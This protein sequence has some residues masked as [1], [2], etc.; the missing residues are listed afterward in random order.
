MSQHTWL[1][2][3]R[4]AV[5]GASEKKRSYGYK[6]TRKLLN[7]NYTT[8]PISKEYETILDEK[9]Y[10]RLTDYEGKID[11]VNFVVNPSIGIEVLDDVIEKGIKKIML[12]PGTYS[13]EIVKK[14][15]EN[16]IEVLES[17]IL[18]LLAWSNK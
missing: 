12:Q 10:S 13:E 17:C 1:K 8:I 9:V 16:G 5:I 4:W 14:A 7:S 6:I 11:V 2:Y 18:V 15:E 3:K